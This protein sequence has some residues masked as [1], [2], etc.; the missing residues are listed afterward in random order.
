MSRRWRPNVIQTCEQGR[1]RIRIHQHKMQGQTPRLAMRGPSNIPS[2]CTQSCLP[3]PQP[4]RMRPRPH[5]HV[6]TPT[7]THPDRPVIRRKPAGV[8]VGVCVHVRGVRGRGVCKH[9]RGGSNAR[10][11][12]RSVPAI[13]VLCE[14]Q[15]GGLG[16][17]QQ[18]APERD[19]GE[20]GHF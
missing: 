3:H 7:P 19:V 6:C 8:C 17:R 12:L 10:L 14:A 16:L 15:V 9:T 4:I 5:T 11:G 1:A 20:V 18:K 2:N 13:F